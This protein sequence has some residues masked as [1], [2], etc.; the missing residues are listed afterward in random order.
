MGERKINKNNLLQ[1][2]KT[3]ALLGK[4]D[5][6][7]IEEP[8]CDLVGVCGILFENSS[9][10]VLLLSLTLDSYIFIAMHSSKSGLHSIRPFFGGLFAHINGENE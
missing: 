1:S 3:P 6:D 5:V 9:K 4:I 10:C 2:S 7:E 8:L